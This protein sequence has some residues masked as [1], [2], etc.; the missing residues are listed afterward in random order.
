MRA[1][2]LKHPWPWAICRLGKRIENRTWA[3]S[4]GLLKQG[5]WFAI[6][7]GQ[8][9]RRRDY[10]AAFN[11]ADELTE[12][13]GFEISAT[14]GIFQTGIVAVTKFGGVVRESSD[15]WFDGPVGWLLS[16]I[17]VCA[18]IKISGKQ[19]LWLL[20]DS[21]SETLTRYIHERE[22]KES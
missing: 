18:P 21:I 12:L 15:P 9:P 16:R 14:K 6:H 22:R 17:F 5:E 4:Q 11:L 13:H 2:T 3:P 7:A 1:L 8:I 20:P 19:G 10:S